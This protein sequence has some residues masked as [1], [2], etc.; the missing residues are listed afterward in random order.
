MISFSSDLASL[1]VALCNSVPRQAPTG[2]FR[3]GKLK[4]GIGRYRY[5]EHMIQAAGRRGIAFLPP[6]LL[7]VGVLF[8][9][10]SGSSPASAAT[11][12]AEAG[13]APTTEPTSAPP[14]PTAEP[15]P[16]PTATAEPTVAPV[17]FGPEFEET[18]SRR[19]LATFV[20]WLNDGPPLR[21]EYESFMSEDMLGALSYDD[22][23]TTQLSARSEIPFTLSDPTDS[24]ITATATLTNTTGEK[25]A[26]DVTV[27]DGEVAGVLLY[28]VSSTEPPTS[29]DEAIADLESEGTVQFLVADGSDCAV[30]S[31]SGEDTVMP[32]A[33]MFKLFVLGAVADAVD[34]GTVTWDEPVTIRDEL[35]SLPS[36]T[37]Q[38]DEP[39][40]A[41][42]VEELAALMI[43]ISDNTA[44]DHLI[45]LVG[46]EAVEA[47]LTDWGHSNPAGMQP[48]LLTSDLFKLKYLLSAD[49]RAAFVALD[50]DAQRN[51][52][53]AIGEG[54]LPE[55]SDFVNEP[56]DLTT[57][58]WFATPLD[59]CRVMV[60]LR[61]TAVASDIVALPS[62]TSE[63][64][65]DQSWT[66]HGS[67]GG[68][69]VGLFALVSLIETTDSSVV[70]VSSV[71]N[72]ERSLDQGVIGEAMFALR[73]FAVAD[74]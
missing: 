33:S 28:P 7:A 64:S 15:T 23:L 65:P 6:A 60:K 32:I 59:L 24:G 55:L 52:L 50:P 48:L 38:N 13:L 17:T 18:E 42:T 31:G 4:T 73:S 43:T 5:P 68:A 58:E 74:N 36:G 25:L 72:E 44:T 9:A 39:G 16:A 37:T 45:D 21:E 26:I 1:T 46:R 69:E 14:S 54:P 8:A 12:V 20:G 34:A 2:G 41:R 22:F 63:A 71:L 49:E 27:V 10:C 40:S 11:A 62:L 35:D 29:F 30:L 3:A 70:V 67:K 66:W 47:G 61:A 57:L 19:A 53:K 51:E 56:R